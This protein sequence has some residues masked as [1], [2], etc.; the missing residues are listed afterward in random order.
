MDPATEEG[1]S[2]KGR[3]N[4]IIFLKSS[5]E[6]ECRALSVCPQAWA[7]MHMSSHTLAW[8]VTPGFAQVPAV[9]PLQSASPMPGAGEGARQLG[10]GHR[11]GCRAVR[12]CIKR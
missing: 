6:A 11:A 7:C 1:N 2:R 8:S 10:P 9:A 5:K 4:E 3:K 12:T